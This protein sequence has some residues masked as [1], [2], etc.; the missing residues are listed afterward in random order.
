[1]KLLVQRVVYFK[2][3]RAVQQVVLAIPDVRERYVLSVDVV[4]AVEAVG[5]QLVNAY[6]ERVV[7]VRGGERLA[8]VQQ[9]AADLLLVVEHLLQRGQQTVDAV[10]PHAKVVV[11]DAGAAECDQ[12]KLLARI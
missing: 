7:G 4:L 5:P 6:A 10:N 11:G 2:G 9:R 3:E 1:M 8:D 12:P